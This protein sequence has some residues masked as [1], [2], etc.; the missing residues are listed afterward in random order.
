M[1]PPSASAIAAF[2]LLKVRASS[3]NPT[4][5]ISAERCSMILI[6]DALKMPMPTGR[7]RFAKSS[8][9]AFSSVSFVCA[10]GHS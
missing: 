9:L 3:I 2:K 6:G 7:R 8:Q 10:K 5:R 1:K 4:M